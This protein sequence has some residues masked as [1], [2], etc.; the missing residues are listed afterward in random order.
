MNIGLHETFPHPPE[1]VWEALNNSAALDQWLMK[2]D[3][4][5]EVGLSLLHEGFHGLGGF[6]L[7]RFIMKKGWTSMVKEQLPVVLNYM[8][9]NGTQFPKE[10]IVPSRGKNC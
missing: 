6:I 8:Q 9:K 10:S 5:P 3:F 7:S 4:K 1:L 2:N